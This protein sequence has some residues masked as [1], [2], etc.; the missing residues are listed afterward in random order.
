MIFMF[1]TF[2]FVLGEDYFSIHER[3]WHWYERDAQLDNKME[4]EG[5]KLSA[6]ERLQ[7]N[8]SEAGGE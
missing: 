2:G 7:K 3:G 8:R 6:N 1:F 4:K 5:K